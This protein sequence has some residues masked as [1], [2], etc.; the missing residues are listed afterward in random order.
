MSLFSQTNP[1]R[2]PAAATKRTLTAEFQRLKHKNQLLTILVLLLVCVMSWA[3]AS[4]FSSQRG[5]KLPADLTKLAKPL[6][7]NLDTQILG[8]L[9]NKRT[10]TDEELTT[11]QI[12]KVVVDPVTQT[13]RVIEINDEIEVAATPTPRPRPTATPISTPQTT[14]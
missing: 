13:E 10:F 3:I 4:L 7:P 8:T 14:L 12:F 2:T 9:E 5:S 6:N 1:I 11:F